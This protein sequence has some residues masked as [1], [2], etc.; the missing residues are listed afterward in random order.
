MGRGKRSGST[1]RAVRG[2]RVAPAH[3]D[4]ESAQPVSRPPVASPEGGPDQSHVPGATLDGDSQ[5]D[6]SE[7]TPLATPAGRWAELEQILEDARLADDSLI[8]KSCDC[9]LKAL[10]LA[11]DWAKDESAELQVESLEHS[12][13]EMRDLLSAAYG[14]AGD[15]EEPPTAEPTELN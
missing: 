6:V 2:E 5:P 14:G 3:P 12:L 7:P 9:R 8:I 15:Q 1:S 4:S 11:S 13:A 10:R